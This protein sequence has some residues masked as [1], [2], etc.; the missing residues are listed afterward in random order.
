MDNVA[1]LL[2]VVSFSLACA[3]IVLYPKTKTQVSPVG[4]TAVAF[5]LLISIDGIAAGIF[6]LISI[7]SNLFSAILVH[8]LLIG[9]AGFG[10][11]KKGIQQQRLDIVE[12]ATAVAF[13][14]VTGLCARAEFGPNLTLHYI[15]SDPANHLSSSMQIYE[16]GSVR[17]MYMAWNFVARIIATISPFVE[18]SLLYKGLII[19]DILFLLFGGLLPYALLTTILPDAGKSRRMLFAIGS[20]IYLLGYPLNGMIYGFCYLGVGVAMATCAALFSYCYW[21]DQSMVSA[22]GL[23]LSLAGLILSYSLFAPIVFLLCFGIF[24]VASIRKHHLSSRH[25]ALLTLLIF[26]IPGILGLIYSYGGIFGGARSVSTSIT[27]EG[28]IY[29]NLYSSMLPLLPFAICGLYRSLS[30]KPDD[31]ERLMPIALITLGIA[32]FM[33]IC[34]ALSLNEIMSTYYFF[35]FYYLF[36]PLLFTCALVGIDY[37]LSQQTKVLTVSLISVIAFCALMEGFR[38]DERLPQLDGK[39]DYGLPQGHHPEF[40]LY[41][42][43]LFY[44]RNASEFSSDVLD[45]YSQAEMLTTETDRLIPVLSS[46]YYQYWYRAI[47]RQTPEYARE[48]VPWVNKPT[49]LAETITSSCDYIVVVSLDF[50][51][52][53]S[54]PGAIESQETATLLEDSV[55]VIYSNDAGYVARVLG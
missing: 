55:E 16:T 27:A 50:S 9:L 6:S 17:S 8:I 22:M 52:T 23:S 42:F 45:L 47:V 15:T 20:I 32:V 37:A 53:E 29:R 21:N 31:D 46:Y 5:F 1:S 24:L 36:S 3:A 28:G 26:I 39:F 18:P 4:W 2:Y 38:I 19:A 48:F 11:S 44:L 12:G 41:R 10:I 14:V 51:I 43:N 13:L 7:P 34:F 30:G 25:I 49:D 35:K 33:A 54:N 40:D